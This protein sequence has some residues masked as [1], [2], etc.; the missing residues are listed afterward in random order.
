MLTDHYTY[1]R[2][3][4]TCK[5]LFSTTMWVLGIK[6]LSRFGCIYPMSHLDI[7]PSL[8]K[9]FRL[10]W[11]LWFF[12]LSLPSV[13][14]IR[15]SSNSY[16]WFR[17]SNLGHSTA[18]YIPVQIQ[19]VG[20]HRVHGNIKV[21]WKSTRYHHHNQKQLQTPVSTLTSDLLTVI[22]KRRRGWEVSRC[23]PETSA[24]PSSAFLPAVIL[25]QLYQFKENL[26]QLW[27]S[28]Y[29]CWVQPLVMRTI[30]GQLLL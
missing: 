25:S 15:A 28:C 19:S 16:W 9:K 26:M 5:S 3:S 30:W 6:S 1:G 27:E 22:P 8:N 12:W 23:T 2:W 11:N 21:F 24:T 18:D 17:E 14:D 29:L 7:P 10:A 13:C 4:T 20:V